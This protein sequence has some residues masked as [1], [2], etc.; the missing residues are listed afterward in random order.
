MTGKHHR[1]KLPS[2][3]GFGEQI[4]QTSVRNSSGK[5]DPP[6]GWSEIDQSPHEMWQPYIL[7]MISLL[8][9]EEIQSAILF[10][11][12]D[13]VN[14]I[15]DH[16]SLLTSKKQDKE[17]KVTHARFCLIYRHETTGE[18]SNKSGVFPLSLFS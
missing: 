6:L 12:A 13:P 15:P 7:C 2:L 3:G 10:Y 1:N 17:D 18:P 4:T 11:T 9:G 14:E 16:K 8:P 5:L